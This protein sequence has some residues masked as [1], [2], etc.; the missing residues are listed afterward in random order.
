LFRQVF[1]HARPCGPSNHGAKR[2]EGRFADDAWEVLQASRPDLQQHSAAI[3]QSSFD[4]DS[5][6]SALLSSRNGLVYSIISAYSNHH[7]LQIRPEDIWFAV[8]TQI[9]SYINA[10]S[11]ELRDKFVEHQ[12]QKELVIEYF[13]GDRYNVDFGTFAKK[14]TSLIE[15]NIIDPELREWI[16][17][18][19]T[20][21]T[22]QDEVIAS[23]LMMCSMQKYF[24]FLC[25]ILCGI[26]SVTLLGEKADYE[27]LLYKLEKLS[28]FGDEPHQF[29]TL[30]KPVIRKMIRTFE[31][32]SDSAVI[33]FWQRILDVNNQ[34]SGTTIYSGWIAAFCF[35]DEEGRR[36][37][38]C[39]PVPEEDYS[40]NGP[41]GDVE[42]TQ[43]GET[44]YKLHSHNDLHLKLD[45]VRYHK[46]DSENVPPGWGK[47]PVKIN[48]NGVIVEAEMVA[49]SVGIA[50][51]SSGVENE[52]GTICLDT[53]KPQV[54]WWIYEK[55]AKAE[56][57]RDDHAMRSRPATQ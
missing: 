41:F 37:H 39:S 56:R 11:E 34:M 49:G 4:D 7:H 36:L 8:I 38:D 53:M 16:L 52:F 28:S 12:G 30:L 6:P 42:E 5:L 21:T 26:P 24:S 55:N 35:W 33:D 23:I 51:S 47:V 14:M 57:H 40:E 17:P 44:R 18:E 9:S 25:R 48:D 54:G 43:L 3:L 45:G 15:K 27:K 31:D 1:H 10:H 22:A 19:F 13:S 50:C 2:I 32:P 29:G 20:T 46:L